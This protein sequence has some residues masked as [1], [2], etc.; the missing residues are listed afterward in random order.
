M[1]RRLMLLGTLVSALSVG[2]P[3]S[4]SADQPTAVCVQQPTIDPEPVV[5]VIRVEG[6]EM[7][8]VVNTAGAGGRNACEHHFANP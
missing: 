5:K 7:F 2:L 8:F 6:V 4:A 3:A 1:L